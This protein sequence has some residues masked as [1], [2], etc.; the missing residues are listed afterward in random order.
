MRVL[1]IS[2]W[3][4]P[5]G[6]IGARRWGEFYNLSKV[7]DDIEFTVLTANWKGARNND[8][9]INYIGE[10]VE[11]FPPSSLNKK[12]TMIDIIKHPTVAIRSLDRSVFS[13]WYEKTKTWLDENSKNEYDIIISSYSPISSIL[14]GNYAK[15]IYKIPHIIDLRDLISSQGQKIKV[16]LINFMDKQ[17]D[18]FITRQADAFLVVSPK[19]KL[20]AVA[21]YSK[22]VHTVYNG[23]S[24]GIKEK[25]IDLCIKDKDAIRILYMGTLGLS[26]NP[27]EILTILN[28]Y[29]KNNKINVEVNFASQDNPN[30]FANMKA[31]NKIKINWL[32]YL[33]KADLEQE[34]HKSDAFLLLEDLNEKGNENLTGKV[35]EYICEKKPILISCH[36]ESDIVSL[37]KEINAGMLIKTQ[38]D[39][40]DFLYEQRYLNIEKVN[41]YTRENQFNILKK[42][43]RHV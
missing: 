43:I 16:P 38:E 34:K 39:M 8:I 20:K 21:L 26:R 31:M 9:N 42:V 19:C 13:S 41:F 14:L 33:S 12:I 30:D 29:A 40:K 15:L 23:L 17:I 11:Y 5:S 37:M 35:F 10:E 32:G 6:V 1:L 18:K 3:F 7:D 4:P 36:K 27:S 28:D 24:V 25:S 2:Y 22:E